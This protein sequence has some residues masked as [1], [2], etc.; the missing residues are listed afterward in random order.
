M[1][2]K[3]KGSRRSG[4]HRDANAPKNA[5]RTAATTSTSSWLSLSLSLSSKKKNLFL[6]KN[7]GGR[8]K[9]GVF[10]SGPKKQKPK[11]LFSFYFFF[12]PLATLGY[13]VE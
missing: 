6:I 11:N 12:S 7:V 1:Y 10:K 13:S 8:E 5:T 2:R 4:P 3:E 9:E